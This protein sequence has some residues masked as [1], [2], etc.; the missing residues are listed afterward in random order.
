MEKLCFAKLRPDAVIPSKRE[1]DAGYDIYAAFDEEYM[2]FEPL[3]TRRVPT[4]LVSAF[5]PEFYFQLQERGSTGTKG[6]SQRCGVIDSGFRSEWM[7]PLTNLNK[8]PLILIKPGK[9][10]LFAGQDVVLY[11]I[12]KA[13]SQA[14]LL[15]VP[16]TVV[17]ELTPEEIRA[18]PSERGSGELG[19]TGK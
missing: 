2:R 15:P 4:G 13:I 8:K 3:E 10:A 19:S 11:P 17:C 1:E 18:I 5:S 14:I 6:I 16:R 9:E 7:I 12:N